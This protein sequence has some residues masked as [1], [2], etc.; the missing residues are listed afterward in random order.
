MGEKAATK[1][2]ERTAAMHKMGQHVGAPAHPCIHFLRGGIETPVEC[3][4]NY[5]CYHCAVHKKHGKKS[6]LKSTPIGKP[7]YSVAS[8]YRLANAYYYHF[9]HTWVHVIHREWV[10]IGMDDFAARVFGK[11]GKIRLPG[12][13]GFLRQGHTGWSIERNGHSAFIQSPLTG[14][15]LA[16]NHAA[17]ANPAISHNDPH[18]KGWLL[19]LEPWFLKREING[20]YSGE[21]CSGW[22]EREN[23]LL[24]N[25]LGPKYERL[26]ATGGEPL[27]DFFGSFPEIGWDRLVRTFL[28]RGKK[29]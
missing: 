2:S 19:H 23:T 26:A 10:R 7:T 1:M 18:N 8:G 6:Q 20:L 27:D 5:E 16:V 22:L 9:G 4:E 25:L 13:G 12:L 17:A 3:S 24:L 21:D 11:A 29:A 28:L 15:V 14:R